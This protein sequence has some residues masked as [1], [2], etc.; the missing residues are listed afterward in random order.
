VLVWVNI[1]GA[2]RKVNADQQEEQICSSPH[3]IDKLEEA[4]LEK[5]WG[6]IRSISLFSHMPAA[7]KE[8]VAPIKGHH[9]LTGARR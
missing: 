2:E 9:A 7:S 3:G 1:T 4:G 5:R 8:V 6:S